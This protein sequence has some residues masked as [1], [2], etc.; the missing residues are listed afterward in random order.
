VF[1]VSLGRP[2]ASKEEGAYTYQAKA[3]QTPPDPS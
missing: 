2:G 1:F 3:R